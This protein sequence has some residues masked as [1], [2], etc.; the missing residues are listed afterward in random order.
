MQEAQ[1]G[2][3]SSISPAIEGAPWGFKQQLEESAEPWTETKVA[4]TSGNRTVF[5]AAL[6]VSHL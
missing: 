6:L 4:E 3:G 5:L 2:G 1:L